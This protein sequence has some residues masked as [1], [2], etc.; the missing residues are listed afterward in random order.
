MGETPYTRMALGV[1]PWADGDISSFKA[2]PVPL[3][4]GLVQY[5]SRPFSGLNGCRGLA[6]LFLFFRSMPDL[7]TE[8]FF[9]KPHH[10]LEW[11]QWH[12][13]VLGVSTVG[14]A[15]LWDMG[16]YMSLEISWL[17][18]WSIKVLLL[19][20]T[21]QAAISPALRTMLPSEKAG[22]PMGCPWPCHLTLHSGFQHRLLY[23][24]ILETKTLASYMLSQ[25]L[26]KMKS[27][28]TQF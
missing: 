14:Y 28:E 18:G 17:V 13:G 5:N 27:P 22:F 11:K 2:F 16:S 1:L 15:C 12:S 20:R 4:H 3:Q 19:S 21:V 7:P 25:W 8:S 24:I 9:Q 23:T 6:F 10:C 26:G